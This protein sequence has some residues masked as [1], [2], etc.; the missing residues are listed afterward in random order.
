MG[1]EQDASRRWQPSRDSLETVGEEAQAEH[2][3]TYQRADTG[4]RI[5]RALT[6]LRCPRARHRCDAG[7]VLGVFGREE[8]V[9]RSS[10][11]RV[12]RGDGGE[13]G[14]VGTVK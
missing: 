13:L 10:G 2:S 8:E 14:V 11:G 9:C 4:S 3:I 7:D 5:A 1:V 12:A 6:L